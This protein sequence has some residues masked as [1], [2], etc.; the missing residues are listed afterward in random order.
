[1]MAQDNN[2][3]DIEHYVEIIEYFEAESDPEEQELW[4]YKTLIKLMEE[5][6]QARHVQERIKNSIIIMNALFDKNES[7]DEFTS[8]GINTTDLSNEDK[9][10]FHT[11]LKKELLIQ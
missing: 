6:K 9:E 4:K 7:P 10:I 8:R 11:H 2:D 5:L 3:I 1:M